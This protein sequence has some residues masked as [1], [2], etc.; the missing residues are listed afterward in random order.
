MDK[1]HFDDWAKSY[2]KD[3]QKYKTVY[4]FAGYEEIIEQII[5]TID[6]YKYTSILDL[7]VGSGYML[8][9]IL[10][11]CKNPQQY[12]GIDFSKEMIKLASEKLGEE[13]F[14]V[15]DISEERIPSNFLSKRFDVILSAYTLH[16]FGLDKKMQI[17]ENYLQL[18]NPDGRMIIADIAF[19]NKK[20]WT[21]VKAQEL[22]AGKWDSDE[23]SGYFI[24]DDFQKECSARNIALDIVN[25]SYCSS[26]FLLQKSY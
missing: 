18:L 11:K 1:N 9:R 10:Q 6:Q 24:I 4:P 21:A 17:I 25:I 16:H 2:E 19:E 14:V 20:E 8:Y 22:E 23:E 15:H 13:H 26:F 12:F 3:L 7:G 5:H